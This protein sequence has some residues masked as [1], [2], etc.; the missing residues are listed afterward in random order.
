MIMKSS[1]NPGKMLKPPSRS[2]FIGAL[3][4][5]ILIILTF[6]ALFPLIWLFMTSLKNEI[7]IFARPP[8]LVFQPTFQAYRYIIKMGFLEKYFLNSL[9]V[10]TL[11]VAVSLIIG[12]LG[13]YSLARF[14]FAGNSFLAFTILASRMLPGVVLVI[15]L[16]LLM[17]RFKLTNTRT[18]LIIAHTAFNLPFVVWILRSYLASIPRELEEAAMIDGASRLLAI[19]KVIAPLSTPGII[20][21]A[22]FTFLLSW[23]EFLFALNLTFSPEAQTMPVAVTGFISARGIA[24]GELSAAATV[25]LLPGLVFGIFARKYIVSG[26]TRG[27]IK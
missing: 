24:W 27:A 1:G 11:T 15:P 7:D 3:R 19:R 25:M 22:M 12:G 26:L 2:S 6:I 4:Y 9:I 8:V 16:Y 17:Q 13:A 14:R 23:N 18:A 5:S 10:A 21:T 20:A